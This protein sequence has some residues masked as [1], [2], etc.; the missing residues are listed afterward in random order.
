MQSRTTYFLY[1]QIWD[2]R[3]DTNQFM[4]FAEQAHAIVQVHGYP[5]PDL[6]SSGA[7]RVKDPFTGKSDDQKNKWRY[8]ESQV[9]KTVLYYHCCLLINVVIRKPLD[10]AYITSTFCAKATPWHLCI[11]WLLNHIYSITNKQLNYEN[12][13]TFRTI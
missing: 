13:R 9:T 5:D 12:T 6:L 3:A 4:G 11:F 10:N 1:F 8:F 7:S 2:Q